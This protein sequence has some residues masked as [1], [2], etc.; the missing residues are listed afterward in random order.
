MVRLLIL[1]LVQP[2]PAP[3]LHKRRLTRRVRVLQQSCGVLWISEPGAG[4]CYGRL[5]NPATP[6]LE[7]CRFSHGER[8]GEPREKIAVVLAYRHAL[9]LDR[10]LGCPGALGGFLEVIHRLFEYGVFVGH[11]LSIWVGML[12]EL[13][14]FALSRAR[15]LGASYGEGPDRI[16]TC[17]VM[18]CSSCL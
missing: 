8:R 18:R 16:P 5:K 9:R 6:S 4:R 11:N 13:D 10:A 15:P 14:C 7:V 3:S 1:P 12:R 2:H 17:A